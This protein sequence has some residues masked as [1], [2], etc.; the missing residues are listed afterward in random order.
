MIQTHLSLTRIRILVGCSLHI[1]N[2]AVIKLV[3]TGISN[4]G[5]FSTFT[6]LI[7]YRNYFIRNI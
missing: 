6:L 2:F 3:V 4:I 1:G 7:F 5:V